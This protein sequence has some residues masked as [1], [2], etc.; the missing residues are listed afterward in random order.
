MCVC[1]C[2]CVCLGGGEG[3]GEEEFN[4]TIGKKIK[5]IFTTN[6]LP[7]QFFRD[8]FL[9]FFYLP[10]CLSCVMILYSDADWAE[11]EMLGI[12]SPRLATCFCLEEVLSAKQ[13]CVAL[14]TTEAEYV[15]L[16]AAAQE[17]IWLQQLTVQ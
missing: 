9:I 5:Q 15:A 4:V 13:A 6:T 14:S 8:V 11:Q 3:R 7:G 10:S 2:V 12:G 16:S 17:V 1:V